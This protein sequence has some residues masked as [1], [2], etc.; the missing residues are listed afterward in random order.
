MQPAPP[1]Q[2]SQ[3]GTETPPVALQLFEQRKADGGGKGKVTC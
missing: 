3:M 2:I 1:Q